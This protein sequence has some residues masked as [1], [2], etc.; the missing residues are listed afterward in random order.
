MWILSLSSALVFGAIAIGAYVTVSCLR[1]KKPVLNAAASVFLGFPGAF[2]GVGIF[3]RCLDDSQFDDKSDERIY[4]AFAAIAMVWV[5]VDSVSQGF[6]E[7][8]EKVR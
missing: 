2:G 4:L 5:A 8:T 6:K 7:S 3:L 1:K